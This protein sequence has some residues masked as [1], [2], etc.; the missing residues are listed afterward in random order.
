MEMKFA[1]A[2]D[3]IK[4]VEAHRQNSSAWIFENGKLKEDII[5][6]DILQFLKDNEDNAIDID[7]ETFANVKGMSYGFEKFEAY[8]NYNYCGNSSEVIEYHTFSD[9]WDYYVAIAIHIGRDVRVGYT[10]FI[11]FRFDSFEEFWDALNQIYI[12]NEDDF[13]ASVSANALSESC[14]IYVDCADDMTFDFEC[15]TFKRDDVID[16]IRNHISEMKYDKV[17]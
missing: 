8:N 13:T 2:Q 12:I 7:S 16:S 3:V 10:N 5:T 17:T 14:S 1:N 9:G 4:V 6:C 11:L 15:Y